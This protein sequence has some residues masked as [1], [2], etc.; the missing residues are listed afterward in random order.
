MEETL[1]NRP[2][3]ETHMTLMQIIDAEAAEDRREDEQARAIVKNAL[4]QGEFRRRPV[5]E[6]RKQLIEEHEELS[7]VA[8]KFAVDDVVR[9]ELTEPS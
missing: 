8:I 6:V 7:S 4:L 2:E 1:E 5:V 3:S 9:G